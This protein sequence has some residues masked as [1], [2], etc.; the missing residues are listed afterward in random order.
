MMINV[1]TGA[2]MLRLCFYAV[3]QSTEH[4]HSQFMLPVRFLMLPFSNT[5]SSQ[6]PEGNASLGDTNWSLDCIL[7]PSYVKGGDFTEDQCSTG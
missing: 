1:A 7:A 4:P 5:K 2:F 6:N 3:S